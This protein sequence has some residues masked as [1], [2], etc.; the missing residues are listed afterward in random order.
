MFY[1]FAAIPLFIAL[2]MF[3][4]YP[5]P[6]K[7]MGM[8]VLEDTTVD[9]AAFRIA[10]QH[11]A[12]VKTVRAH[13][14]NNS[15]Y[16]S[17]VDK[18][19]VSSDNITP[20]D[21]FLPIGYQND[22]LDSFESTVYC[23]AE[24]DQDGVANPSTQCKNADFVYVFTYPSIDASNR[25]YGSGEAKVLAEKIGNYRG[26]ISGAYGIIQ[27]TL[28]APDA[29][30]NPV[31][32][33]RGV[34]KEGVLGT[35]DLMYEY[36][37]SAFS[38]R[39]GDLKGKLVLVTRVKGTK[40]FQR[41]TSRCSGYANYSLLSTSCPYTANKVILASNKSGKLTISCA[42]RYTFELAG[43]AGK[44]YAD[45]KGNGGRI[46]I[47]N[48]TLAK[49]TKISFTTKP[50]YKKKPSKPGSAMTLTIGDTLVAV[51]G[52]GGAYLSGGGG[53]QGGCGS[54]GNGQGV[55]ANC[56]SV[57]SGAA[58]GRAGSNAYGGSGYC[59]TGA[60]YACT[61]VYNTNASPDP[62]IKINYLGS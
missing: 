13:L 42:G 31:G 25:W 45:V 28:P 46:T 23:L 17:V 60:G 48:R 22:A 39:K 35:N 44:D 15:T 55:V 20:I 32:S 41:P 38:C 6:G 53:Y 7:E 61:Q 26:L 47:S 1:W 49:D 24:T 10:M 4:L 52:G 8:K 36:L 37:P 59:N 50:G 58:G 3:T 43:G 14:K 5:R 16:T 40:A 33:K 19:V 18:W 62:Y 11:D 21:D 12:M 56:V 30:R 9:A 29:D 2:A 57:T 51:A 27:E 34:I 54:D